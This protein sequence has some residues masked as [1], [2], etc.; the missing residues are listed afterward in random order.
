[1]RIVCIYAYICIMKARV[2][3]T[4]ENSLLTKIKKYAEEQGTS[5]SEIAEQYFIKLT[6][7]KKKK[8]NLFDIVAELPAVE[9]P[10]DYDFKEEYYKAKGAKYGD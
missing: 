7:A 1:M 8:T 2:N 4:I 9:Y 10:E 3:L 6:S 5:V